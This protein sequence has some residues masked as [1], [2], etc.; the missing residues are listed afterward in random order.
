VG[1][2]CEVR[3]TRKDAGEWSVVS[4]V[5]IDDGPPQGSP[6]PRGQRPGGLEVQ[7]IRYPAVKCWLGCCW[8]W[9]GG[10]AC[11][12]PWQLTRGKQFSLQLLCAGQLEVHPAC[13][14]DARRWK[15]PEA[16]DN[17]WAAPGTG[18][19]WRRCGVAAGL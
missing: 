10:G 4:N 12:T 15:I 17:G 11:K 3:M 19:L 5:I 6:R 13:R 16:A 7:S 14:R 2:T 8:R 9:I 1:H 18:L